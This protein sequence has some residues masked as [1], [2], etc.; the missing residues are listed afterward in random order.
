MIKSDIYQLA[1][2]IDGKVINL[3]SPLS[4]LDVSTD[5]RC[6][7][8]GALF[9]AL[10]G[11]RFDGHSFAQTAVDAG[12]SAL[13]VSR[14]L[15][16]NI[17]QIIVKDTRI[18]LGQLG[19]WIKSQLNIKT[20]A[21]T[22][23]CGKTSVKEMA[24]GIL[25]QKGTTLATKGNFNNDIG[26]P[27]TLLRLTQEHQYAVIE[28][29]ANHEHEIAYSVD[30]VKPDVALINNV[31]AAHLEGFKSIQGVAKAKGEIFQGLAKDHVAI[32]NASIEYKD[33]WKKDLQGKQAF[34]FSID[35]TNADCYASDI[36]LDKSARAHFTLHTPQGNTQ[37]QLPVP[38]EHN[39]AN[40]LAASMATLFMGVSLQQVK[41]GLENLVMVQGRVDAQ[42][43]T[44]NLRIIDD[45]YNASSSA[46]K[47]AAKL[48]SSYSGKRILVVADMKEL[49]TESENVH[50]DVGKYVAQLDIDEVMTLGDY[51][52][53]IAQKVQGQHFVD[54][55]LLNE[56]LKGT[57]SSYLDQNHQVTV[58][59]KG[60]RSMK[61]ERVVAFL[62]ETF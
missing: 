23:S 20:L 51:A 44:E 25:R 56:A 27:L 35:D 11:E 41:E 28:L 57:I 49:G 32:Y 1:Q 12:A 31:G 43:L 60:A 39:V 19:A 54:I 21:I 47:A 42:M 48:L 52:N 55:S 30:L 24:A 14:E 40:A 26:V 15:D 37:V 22:G 7:S 17:P 59:V 36:K 62:K 6:I 45:T 9:V 46:M 38:G 58:L 18:A 4:I 50:A 5:T 34:T 3:T 16:I 8:Q 61:M 13:L 53:I 33:L 2:A 10:V 29:G